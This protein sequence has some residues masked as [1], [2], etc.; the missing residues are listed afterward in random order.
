M[1]TS[2][3]FRYSS[4]VIVFLDVVVGVVVVSTLSFANGLIKYFINVD[5]INTFNGK[6][7]NNIINK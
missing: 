1:D 2:I 7:I 5:D 6:L 4:S 3:S